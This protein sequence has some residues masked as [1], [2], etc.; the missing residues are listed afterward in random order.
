MRGST[1]WRV[2]CFVREVPLFGEYTAVSP[3]PWRGV[4]LL[5]LWLLWLFEMAW[6]CFLVTEK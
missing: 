3:V 4:W 2:S 5:G 6:L 1:S